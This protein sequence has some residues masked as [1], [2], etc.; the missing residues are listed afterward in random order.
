MISKALPAV[1]PTL[2]HIFL[3]WVDAWLLFSHEQEPSASETLLSLEELASLFKD[4]NI[5]R[6]VSHDQL[7][8]TIRSFKHHLAD[9]RITF[10]GKKPPSCDLT[11]LLSQNYN[12]QSNCACDQAQ[13]SQ[14]TESVTITHRQ[15]T[16]GTI[17]GMLNAME[18]VL[19]RQDEWHGTE[20]FTAEKLKRATNELILANTDIQATPDT[21]QGPGTAATLPIICAPDRR[22]NPGIDGSTIISN[23]LYPTAE[24]LKI[25]A[26]A[27]YFGVIACGASL[28]DEGLARAVADS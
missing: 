26:D 16:C 11:D 10:G 13:T 7:I 14:R 19:A 25:C 2:L 24:Q 27:K 21:C 5:H 18:T 20:L 23:Q 12:P 6:L 4:E 28:C 8:Q 3:A 9:G 15:N 17:R 1:Q 22:P